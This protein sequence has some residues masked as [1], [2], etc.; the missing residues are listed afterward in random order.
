MKCLDSSDSR[1]LRTDIEARTNLGYSRQVPMPHDA[2][3]RIVC[4]QTEQELSERVLLGK[5][6][7]VGRFPLRV[8]A[9][10]VTNP[11]GTAVEAR[12][13]RPLLIERATC[14]NGSIACNVIMVPHGC[15][16]ACPVTGNDGFQREL[17]VAARGA[18]MDD[19]QVNP[20]VVLVLTTVQNSVT[21]LRTSLD[22]QCCGKSR[23]HGNGDFQ[24]F[25][26]KGILRIILHLL[27]PPR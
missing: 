12:G 22:A 5:G 3:I 21:H 4:F 15:E 27:P 1:I 23:Q 10:F 13:M 2:D 11:D 6:T 18:A 7:G 19:N 20:P 26:P 9:S 8:Q 24:Y 16:T 25:S 14:M 17:P